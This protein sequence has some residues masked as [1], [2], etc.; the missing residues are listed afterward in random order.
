VRTRNRVLLGLIVAT[1]LAAT[2]AFWPR[3]GSSITASSLVGAWRQPAPPM[4]KTPQVRMLYFLS[5]GTGST[6]IQLDAIGVPGMARPFGF[7]YSV[8]GDR[9]ELRY[10]DGGSDTLQVDS[11]SWARV[12]ATSVG[13]QTHV[14][15]GAWT[16]IQFW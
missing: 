12:N 15:G 13:S 9:V 4:G 16:R 10:M 1:V 5:D 7:T 14:P 3:P 6:N 2:A 8:T 11:F